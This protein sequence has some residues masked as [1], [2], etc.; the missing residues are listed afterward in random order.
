MTLLAS[1]GPTLRCG[2]L[3]IDCR[4]VTDRWL[5][6][7]F[8]PGLEKGWG[9][10]P[11]SLPVVPDRTTRASSQPPSSAVV[12]PTAPATGTHRRG[13]AATLLWC[14]AVATAAPLRHVSKPPAITA[15]FVPSLGNP[16][17][18]IDPVRPSR[19]HGP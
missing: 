16:G 18:P 3:G 4:T 6:G 11:S 7:R 17:V 8:R 1:M 12:D 15:R 14:R 19:E 5:L 10:G 13:P 2:C 9:F